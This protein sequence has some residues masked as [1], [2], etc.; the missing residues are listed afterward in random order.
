MTLFACVRI[1]VEEE[2]RTHVCINVYSIERTHNNKQTY[3]R[4]KRIERSVQ[5]ANHVLDI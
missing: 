2:R 1:R 4:T 5:T 3:Q